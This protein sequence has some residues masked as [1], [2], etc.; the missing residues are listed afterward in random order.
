[1]KRNPEKFGNKS[2]LKIKQ[3]RNQYSYERDPLVVFWVLNNS[4]GICECCD[5][6]APFIDKKGKPFL[7]VHHVKYLASGGSDLITN[8]VALCPNCHR[9]IHYSSEEESLRNFLYQKINRLQ[10]E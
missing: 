7:E 1:M 9:K 2:P 10:P 4:K 8:T 5:K 6:K 3:T